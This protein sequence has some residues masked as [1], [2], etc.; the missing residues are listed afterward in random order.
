MKF[1]KAYAS[2]LG[3]AAISL[4]YFYLWY[5]SFQGKYYYY[6]DIQTD[7]YIPLNFAYALDTG[8]KIYS[9]FNTSFGMLFGKLNQLAFDIIKSKNND[10]YLSD[11]IHIESSLFSFGLLGLFFLQILFLKPL[12]NTKAIFIAFLALTLALSMHRIDSFD[13]KVIIWENYNHHMYALLVLQFLSLIGFQRLKEKSILKIL[14]ISFIQAICLFVS[15]NYKINFFASC[16]FM[17]FGFWLF[18]DNSVKIKSLI[19]SLVFASGLFQIPNFFWDSSIVDYVQA[20]LLAGKGKASATQSHWGSY[21]DLIQAGLVF[22]ILSNLF[23]QYFVAKI[24]LKFSNFSKKPFLSLAVRDS[25]LCLAILVATAGTSG[26]MTF[27]FHLFLML[28]LFLR[29]DFQKTSSRLKYIPVLFLVYFVIV[30]TLSLGRVAQFKSNPENSHHNKSFDFENT[31]KWNS[32]YYSFEKRPGYQELMKLLD[33]ESLPNSELNFLKLASKID[34]FTANLPRLSNADVFVQLQK[35]VKIMDK[36]LVSK[37]ERTQMLGFYNP[38]PVL[39][40]SQLPIP[41]FNWVHIGVNF[42]KDLIPLLDESFND[43]DFIALKI[44]PYIGHREDSALNCYFLRWNKSE[45]YPF[46]FLTADSS[47][48]YFAKPNNEIRKTANKQKDYLGIEQ[49]LLNNCEKWNYTL[50]AN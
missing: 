7:F 36:Y 22:V 41:S 29:I 26:R 46:V 5:L 18:F 38:L 43:S 17:A 25:F 15:F 27:I 1:L 10:F 12:R 50:P 34:V 30:N 32:F 37:E 49:E 4:I 33:I 40:Q 6:S 9:E 13:H 23:E 48:A 47:G 8:K 39:S 44:I 14:A 45:E 2:K 21:K 16:S 31:E 24:P 42:S 3:L 11:L 28:Y 19:L 20:V 35:T